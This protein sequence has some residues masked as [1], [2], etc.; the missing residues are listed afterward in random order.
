MLAALLRNDKEGCKSAA[1]LPS[2]QAKARRTTSSMSFAGPTGK[3]KTCIG[4]LVV[5]Q[6]SLASYRRRHA[7]HSRSRTEYRKDSA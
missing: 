3:M 4:E 2:L 5:I 1:L 7:G 6:L